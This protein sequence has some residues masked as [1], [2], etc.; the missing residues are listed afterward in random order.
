MLKHLVRSNGVFMLC[1]GVLVISGAVVT[2][3]LSLSA[4]T[5]ATASE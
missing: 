2:G 5:S 3:H 4:T 1:L